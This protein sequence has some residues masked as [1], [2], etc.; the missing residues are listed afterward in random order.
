MVNVGKYTIHG[1]YG[2]FSGGSNIEIY[3]LLSTFQISNL[4]FAVEFLM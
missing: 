2:F 4:S 1:S 3:L